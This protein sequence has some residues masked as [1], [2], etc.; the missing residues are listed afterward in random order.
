MDHGILIFEPDSEFSTPLKELLTVEGFN[1]KTAADA[2]AAQQ[3]LSD[4]QYVLILVS[5]EVPP[6]ER[7]EVLEKLRSVTFNG[8]IV[9]TGDPDSEEAAA[10]ARSSGH[11]ILER[12]CDPEMLK[13]FAWLAVKQAEAIDDTGDKSETADPADSETSD[14]VEAKQ[15]ETSNTAQLPT[16]APLPEATHPQKSTSH[17]TVSAFPALTHSDGGIDGFI[18]QAKF[19]MDG[20]DTLANRMRVALESLHEESKRLFE[21]EV[22]QK[23]QEKKIAALEDRVDGVQK[24]ATEMISSVHSERDKALK[25]ATKAT[26][27]LET[28][29]V[30]LQKLSKE[31]GRLSAELEVA[32]AQIEASRHEASGAKSALLLAL[33]SLITNCPEP[34]VAINNNGAIVGVSRA[35][36]ALMGETAQHLIGQAAKDRLS[37]DLQTLLAKAISPFDEELTIEAATGTGAQSYCVAGYPVTADKLKLQVL[38]LRSPERAITKV[39]RPEGDLGNMIEEFKEKLFSIRILTETVAKNTESDKIREVAEEVTIELDRLL[40]HVDA[41]F[42]AE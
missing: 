35:L 11:P 36:A 30:E 12:P 37:A 38:Y 23:T 17:D 2:A 29:Q 27:G 7:A 9:F 3:A 16:P 26:S 39:K 33:G 22:Q 28:A 34:V 8:K 41:L 32:T 19:D 18:K 1:V 5:L 15:D 20:L 14:I 42:K 10:L 4:G 31:K 6:M 21:Y 40:D 25:N 13:D 24:E